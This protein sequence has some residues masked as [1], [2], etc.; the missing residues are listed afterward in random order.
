MLRSATGGENGQHASVIQCCGK[1]S[2]ITV[3][4]CTVFG[5]DGVREPPQCLKL[6]KNA[7]WTFY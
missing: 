2:E 1:N 4:F 3:L 7:G 5:E 6:G